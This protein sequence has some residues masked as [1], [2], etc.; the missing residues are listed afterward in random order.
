MRG[1]EI[2]YMNDKFGCVDVEG[3]FFAESIHHK[4]AFIASLRLASQWT[5]EDGNTVEVTVNEYWGDES[6]YNF[7]DCLQRNVYNH[8][9]LMQRIYESDIQFESEVQS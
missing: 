5:V 9:Q 2:N 1:F 4:K 6:S 8:Q 7:N 3:P